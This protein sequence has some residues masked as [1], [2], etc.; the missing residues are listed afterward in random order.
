MGGKFLSVKHAAGLMGVTEQAIYKAIGQ[1][2]IPA[3]KE[4]VNRK[5]EVR[6]PVAPFLVFLKDEKRMLSEKL[7]RL[8]RAEN[9][10]RSQSS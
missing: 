1:Q 9:I 10:L 3:E 5:I 6:I 7:G 8:D 4:M 2:T